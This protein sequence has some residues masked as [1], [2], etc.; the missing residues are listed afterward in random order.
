MT[1]LQELDIGQNSGN[2]PAVEVGQ[3]KLSRYTLWKYTGTQKESIVF[4]PSFFRGELLNLGGVRVSHFTKDFPKREIEIPRNHTL[5]E[6]DNF[7]TF[8]HSNSTRKGALKSCFFS[9]RN[10]LE[11]IGLVE[12]HGVVCQIVM[13]VEVE[14]CSILRMIIPIALEAQNLPILASRTR[15]RCCL[16][17]KS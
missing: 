10:R 5:T 17:K 8:D 2:V 4:Q 9:Q 15:C 13:D 6:R 1:K 12:F 16:G 14:T 7:L 11:P 3:R